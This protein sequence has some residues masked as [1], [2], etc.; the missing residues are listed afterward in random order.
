MYINYARKIY[1]LFIVA[2]IVGCGGGGS[3]GGQI[4]ST[5]VATQSSQFFNGVVVDGYIRGSDVFIDTNDNYTKDSSENAT[6]TDYEGK[7]TNLKYTNGNLISVGGF[8]LDTA[9]PLDRFFLLNKLSSWSSFTVITPITTV[10][11]FM[12]NPENINSILGI[13]ASINIYTTDPVAHLTS[14]GIYNDLYEKGNQIA[15]MALSLQNAINAYNTSIDNTKDY[16]KGIAEE[17]E[18][19]YAIANESVD[20]KSEEFISKVVDNLVVSKAST[21]D[22]AIKTNIKSILTAVVPV[23]RTMS[24]TANT[25]AIQN[26]AFSTLQTDIKA[27]AT[28]TASTATLTS[29]ESNILTYIASDQTI[30]LDE[31]ANDFVVSVKT[32]PDSSTTV[33]NTA[34]TIDV[35]ANDMI[36][37]PGYTPVITVSTPSNGS[38]TV[39][40]NNL[41]TYSPSTNFLGTDTFTYTL[42]LGSVSSTSTVTIFILAV[43]TNNL[44]IINGLNSSIAAKENQKTVVNVNA[45]DIETSSLAYS[46]SGADSSYFNISNSGVLTFNIAPDYETPNDEDNN[47]SYVLT[48]SVFDGIATTNQTIAVVVQNVPDLVSGIAVDGYVAG[49]TVFQDLDNNGALNFGEPNTSTNAM[50]SFSLTL[51]SVN[52]SAPVRIINGYDLATNEIHP[53]IMDISVT[54]T[55]SYIITPI[56]TLVGRLKIQDSTLTGNVPESIIAATLGINLSDSPND[57]ILGFDPIAYFTGSD[58]TL[59]NE[60]KPIFGASQ[61]LMALGGSNYSVN[62][63]VIDQVLTTLSTTLTNT[64][65]SPIT[66]SSASDI[67]AIKQDAYDAIFNGYVDTALANNPPINYVQF[68]NNKAVMTDYLNGSSSSQVEYSLYGV[69]DGSSTLVADLVGAKLDYENLKQILDNEGTGTPMDLSFELSSLPIGSGTTAVTMKLFHGNDIIQGSNEDYL[70]VA[71]TADWESDGSTLSIKLP[72]NSNLVAKFFDRGGTILTKTVTNSGEDIF[73]VDQDGPNRPGSLKL[74]LSQLF[75]LFPSQVSGLSTYLDGNSEFTYFVEMGDFTIYDHLGNAFNKIQG[76]FGVTSN[77]AITV[78]ADDIYIHEN[79]TSQNLTFRLSQAS[80]SNVSVDYAIANSSTASSSDYTLNPGTVTIP[81]GSTSATLAVAVTNDTVIESQEEIKLTLS[82]PQNAVLSR[83]SASVYITDGEEILSND[84]QREI[85]A[86]NVYKDSKQSIN[87]YIKNKLDTSTVTISETAYTY[88]QVLINNSITSDVNAYVDSIVDDY[89]IVAEALI[90]AV[91]TKTNLFVDAE[92]SGFTTYLGYTQKLTQL[93]SGLKGLNVSQIVGTNINANGSYPDGQTTTTLQTAMNGQ[94]DTLVSLA[95]DTV[96]D[97]LGIDTNT[98]FPNANVVIG[99]DGDDTIT[100]T[101][102]SDL[103]ATFNGADTV[104]AAAG[105]DKVLG[106]NG[107]DTFN[108]QDGNDHL[109]GYAGND[110]LTGDAGNDKVLGGLGND[111]INGGAGDDDLRGESGNDTITSGAGSDTMTGGLGDDTFNINSKSGA[112]TDIIDGGS[113]TDTLDIDYTGI[114]NLGDFTLTYDSTNSYVILTDTNGGIIKFKNIENLT[115]GDIDYTRVE[116]DRNWDEPSVKDAYWNSTEGVLYLFNSS[117]FSPGIWNWDFRGSDMLLGLTDN[118]NA[119]KDVTVVGSPYNDT[120]NLNMDRA[121]DNDAWYSGNWTLNIGDGDDS[122]NSAKLKNGDSIDMGAGDDT[123]SIMATGIEGTPTIAN[124]DLAKLDGGAGNDTL[125][126]E[127]SGS[128]TTELTLTTG[129]S[130][131]FENIIGTGGAETIKGD[132]NANKLEGKGA[133]DTLYGY[134]GNDTLEGDGGN[135]T[136]YGGN[137]NDT[138]KGEAGDDTLDGGTGTDTLTGGNGTDTFVIRSGDGSTIADANVI[139]DFTD[140]TDVIGMENIVYDDLTIAQGSGTYASHTLVSAT[141]TGEYLLII[142]NATASNIT[143]AD[144][145]NTS[146][147]AQTLNGT[148]GNNILIGGA[149]NDTFNGGAGSDELYGYGGN[150]TFNINSKSGAFTD[151]IDGGSGTDTLDIDYTGISN[152][153]DF[154]LTYDSTNS[155]VILTDTNGGI[156]KFKNIENLTV[157]DIDYTRVEE[158]RNWDEPSVK[159]AYWNSTEGVLYLFNSS[160]FS[161]GIWNWDFRGS[162][163]LLGLTDNENATK[164][165]TVVGSP[166]NDTFNLNM[167]RA[168]DND[169]WYSGN[170]T[171]NIGDGDDSFNSAKLKNG[172]SIDMGA[173]DDTVSI[174]ATGIE[175]TPTIANLDLAKLDGG[176]GNDTL[177]FEESGS[178]T[179]ELTLTTGGSTNFENII[180]TGGAETIKGDANAN[181]LEGKG[182]NDT[183]YGYAGNDTLEGDGGNDTLY[184]GNDNDTLKGEAGD[185]T[186]DGGTGTDTLTGGNGTDTF[187]IRSGDGSTIADANVI[188]DF[189]DGTDLIGMSGLQ[190]SQLTIE[191]GSGDYS[192]HVIVKKTDTGEFLMIIQNISSSNISSADFS[193]I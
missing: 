110:I 74:R 123:V 82:N 180:G 186:L 66:M 144:F 31:I 48:V 145:S 71:L 20:I 54:E 192:N 39:D 128:N 139:T 50:G 107:V 17:L 40:S 148:S 188:T 65:G 122:F 151:I 126:F 59:A 157:G 164:D 47:N 165:V 36:V 167:D 99:A 79:T 131:N 161:P 129:G 97:I 177:K 34:V 150:D 57:S 63:Y 113:G 142:Q 46:I 93:I 108:G 45:S 183:L 140:G 115:V 152:L 5:S 69:H 94:V 41:L 85:L 173:G 136:L 64:S 154:T 6:T 18:A 38:V 90:N 174:M 9:N 92:L 25:T 133:N 58:A 43:S 24:N 87:A 80:S 68:K 166:Y 105:N 158:D 98:N 19:A 14:G 70:Q 72:A 52:N 73:T 32:E 51:S 77:S 84:S 191:Q 141:A 21:I 44:P 149:G 26:F 12:D 134:A 109:Y 23:T 119:T 146:T 162:D 147:E 89:E 187:V 176:A 100:G 185:D 135:D 83:S 2:F 170:W 67:T 103:I 189:T 168:D 116:E 86:D 130:T 101:S 169:A 4:A 153:G 3:D 171:L 179:T 55:G 42:S 53:S 117:S 102:G 106:G 91:M 56:S 155:Y 16:F 163:M 75:T 138:L 33:I 81:A 175:G 15:I 127:E 159:D 160:S 61:L 37:N 88:S 118:E 114:S 121:D 172:D 10:A 7:F 62:K 30:S 178:N 132:A 112:F 78:T 184:G 111:T 181:K 143:A 104:N 156:I 120:F 29:Y 95:A 35:P 22:S 193:A 125:K 182:A 11:A 137:D 27:I 60:S 76:T 28:D 8:D 13:D 96:A 1:F 190:Y 124:L 49:A